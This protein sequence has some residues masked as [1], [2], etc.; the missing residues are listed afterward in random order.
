MGWSFLLNSFNERQG[1]S[2]ESVGRRGMND[3]RSRVP[4]RMHFYRVTSVVV[5]RWQGLG[6]LGLSHVCRG[7]EVVRGI[8]AHRVC[9]PFVVSK[10]VAGLGAMSDATHITR[11]PLSKKIMP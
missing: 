6:M 2:S 1:R 8:A 10:G 9:G 5:V 3:K 4:S 7:G 11:D